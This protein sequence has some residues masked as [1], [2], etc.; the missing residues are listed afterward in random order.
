MPVHSC[1]IAPAP[2][3]HCPLRKP[4]RR[5]L[6]SGVLSWPWAASSLNL[7]R[8]LGYPASLASFAALNTACKDQ[9]GAQGPVASKVSVVPTDLYLQDVLGAAFTLGQL[10]ARAILLE[11]WATSCSI[12]LAEMPQIVTIQE[13]FAAKGLQVVALAMPYDR[14]DHVLHYAKAQRL[15]FPIAIDPSGHL[16]KAV[17]QQHLGQG[18][19][20]G[21]PTR[22]LLNT[23]GEVIYR[24]QGALAG[25]G[26][27]LIK[28]I[29]D[30]L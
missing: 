23:K 8:T 7:A 2:F 14:P 17:A 27:A 11:F 6:L 21:T 10:K 16:L 9:R 30:A 13:T 1:A 15:P 5:R 22:L 18:A 20:E 3:D 24:E 19:I 26:Q 29:R 28:S 25:Q 4:L 12:C